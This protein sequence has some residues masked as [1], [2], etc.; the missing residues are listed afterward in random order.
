MKRHKVQ[1]A[2]H[3]GMSHHNRKRKNVILPAI[4]LNYS[5]KML[6]DLSMGKIYIL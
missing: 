2:V 3:T 6:L 4:A 1:Y 5:L